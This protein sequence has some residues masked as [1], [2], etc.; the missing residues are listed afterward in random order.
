M[1]AVR[2]YQEPAIEP[3]FCFPLKALPSCRA[4]RYR[5]YVCSQFSL[6]LPKL[7]LKMEEFRPGGIDMLIE[8][9]LGMEKLE[10]SFTTVGCG[11]LTRSLK[12]SM[13]NYPRVEFL[14]FRH[15]TA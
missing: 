6:T 14:R 3:V 8:T 12:P 4:F 1:N 10:L 13:G 7:A 11:F 15:I 5:P 2:P 9:D